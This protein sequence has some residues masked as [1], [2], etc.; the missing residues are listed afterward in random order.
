MRIDRLEKGRDILFYIAL[1]IECIAVIIDKSRLINPY[2]TYLFRGT[3][4]LFLIVL[5]L[6][7]YTARE[8]IIIALAIGLGIA[9]Y[10]YTG[11]DE[12]T[13]VAV[14]VAACKDMPLKRTFG[15][16]FFTTLA[17]CLVIVFLALTGIFGEVSV[18]QLYRIE[19]GVSTRVTLGFGHPNALQCMYYMLLLMTLYFFDRYMRWYFYLVLTA[20]T[21]LVCYLTDSR[22]GYIMGIFSIL[23]C[24]ILHYPPQAD[25]RRDEVARFQQKS[26]GM[27]FLDI[28]LRSKRWPFALGGLIRCACVAVS[29]LFAVYSQ[30]LGYVERDRIATFLWDLDVPLNGRIQNLFWTDA[31]R[32]GSITTWQLFSN[33]DATQFFDLGWVRLFYWYGIIPAAVTV[34]LLLILL[35]ECY[36]RR[37][38]QALMLIV[39]LSVY[40]VIEAHLIS[41]YIGRN[42]LLLIFGAYW[43]SM[44]RV[45]GGEGYYLPELVRR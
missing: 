39:S 38:G 27:Q 32:A 3:V 30:A 20:L 8:W 44:L 21:I 11:R 26:F 15:T 24:V 23:L 18:T 9:S 5:L 13:R 14:F 1:I 31:T 41:I 45:D 42:F 28:G 17:G 6:T 36:R 2:T 35:A 43:C 40:T 33:A 22:T 16:A 10:L 12:I 19:D 25:T 7:E 37:D 29:I 4:V 34:I